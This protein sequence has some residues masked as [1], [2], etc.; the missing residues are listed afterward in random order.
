M[1]TRANFCHTSGKVHIKDGREWRGCAHCKSGANV[2]EY[3]SDKPDRRDAKIYLN[4]PS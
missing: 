4:E 1:F 2:L 3:L